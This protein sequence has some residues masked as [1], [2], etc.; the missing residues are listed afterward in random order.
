MVLGRKNYLFPGSDVGG[1]R[2]AII[3]SLIGTAK[4]NGLDP[5]KYLAEA[6]ARIADY[7]INR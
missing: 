2:A 5:E 1:A 6:L 7:P 4:P 3:Y